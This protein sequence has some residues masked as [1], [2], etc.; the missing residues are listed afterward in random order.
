MPGETDTPTTFSSSSMYMRVLVEV[1]FLQRSSPEKSARDQAWEITQRF[2][3]RE[4]SLRVKNIVQK[5]PP[6]LNE[7]SFYWDGDALPCGPEESVAFDKMWQTSSL[8][9]LH[10]LLSAAG[11]V[12]LDAVPLGLQPFAQFICQP[13]DG[14]ARL[15]EQSYW[16][17]LPDNEWHGWKYSAIYRDK[18]HENAGVA[19]C[20][21][22]YRY[23]LDKCLGPTEIRPCQNPDKRC[24][25]M[26]GG[27]NHR[28]AAGQS[29]VAILVDKGSIW[30]TLTRPTVPKSEDGNTDPVKEV[31]PGLFA[32][33]EAENITEISRDD[34]TWASEDNSATTI[35]D[36]DKVAFRVLHWLVHASALVAAGTRTICLSELQKHIHSIARMRAVKNADRVM[37]Y[38]KACVDADLA[39]IAN[40]LEGTVDDAARLIHVVLHKLVDTDLSV[41][42]IASETVLS[43]KWRPAYEK[44]FE[45]SIVKPLLEQRNTRP[46]Q[47]IAITTPEAENDDTATQARDGRQC[48]DPVPYMERKCISE[49]EWIDDVPAPVR[50]QH[51]PHI[52]RSVP[53]PETESAYNQLGLHRTDEFK[54]GTICR[55]YR[56]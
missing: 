11:E 8:A 17:G 56:V 4:V 42:E 19:E 51:L 23:L 37:W 34:Y 16:P 28:F 45:D 40:L 39:A 55:V 50:A 21:C 53:E 48:I 24:T 26:N 1:C 35:R 49:K 27:T 36:L 41:S 12:G 46:Q 52:L 29:L 14:V 47:F 38:L 54:V 31:R 32:L 43:H 15:L 10:A 33:T 5:R 6:P 9:H 7:K 20:K 25:L 2:N 44:W 30:S 18:N 22:G 3:R 13:S